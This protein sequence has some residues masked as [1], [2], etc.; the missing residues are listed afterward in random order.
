MKDSVK[1]GSSVD[2]RVDP[3]VARHPSCASIGRD[4]RRDPPRVATSHTS[5]EVRTRS[6]DD[7]RRLETTG[8]VNLKVFACSAKWPIT[9]FKERREALSREC[10]ALTSRLNKSSRTLPVMMI[11]KSDVRFIRGMSARTEAD[12]DVAWKRL[13]RMSM[14]CAQRSRSTSTSSR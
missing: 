5:V 10:H 12:D 11:S 8:T 3:R 13:F 6:I 2:N 7:S 1:H 14:N 4:Q 9:V